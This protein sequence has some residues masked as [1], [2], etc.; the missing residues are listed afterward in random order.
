MWLSIKDRGT[1]FGFRYIE[2]LLQT[3]G[4]GIE[5]VNQAE[6]A[7]EDLLGD[8]QSIIYSFCARLYGQRRAK[9]KTEK[10]VEELNEN[11][12]EDATGREAH[13]Q[14]N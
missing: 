11:G 1:C 6:N 2:T 12:D 5:V 7:N 9:R 10:I 8:L 3:T 14:Q 4:R 13:D